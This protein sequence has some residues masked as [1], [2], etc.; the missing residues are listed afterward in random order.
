MARFYREFMSELR[1]AG[2]DVQ[3]NTHPQEVPGAIPFEQDEQHAAY[4]P[5]HARRLHRILL[6]IQLVLEQFRA[7]FI[8]KASPV[9]FF[10]GSFDLAY[11]RFSG[12]LAPRR[13]GVITGEAY[14]HECC[15]VGW[16]PGSGPVDGPAFYAYAAPPPPGY[17]EQRLRPDA[18]SYR[19]DLGEFLLMYDD[20]RA[21]ASP[22]TEILQF[23]QSAYDAAANLGAW[24]RAALDR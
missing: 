15:S 17:S 20:V 13:K 21:S 1:A 23:A 16:W 19:T 10:W 5:E 6:S 22:E 14:S 24:D 4:S 2:I 11:T 9:H 8:G 18:A 12:R 7:R 3:I